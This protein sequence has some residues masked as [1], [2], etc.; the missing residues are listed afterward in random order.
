ML[1]NNIQ[2]VDRYNRPNA[3]TILGLRTLFYN[4]GV[5]VDPVEIAGVAIFPASSNMLPEAI[6]NSSG[7]ISDSVFPTFNTVVLSGNTPILIT[8]PLSNGINGF[9]QESLTSQTINQNPTTPFI[10]RLGVGDYVN[11]IH[12][13]SIG[14]YA[15]GIPSLGI[16]SYY[17]FIDSTGVNAVNNIGVFAENSSSEIKQP[18][19]AS[20]V[21]NRP[22]K[23]LD[24][25]T[26]KFN[27]NS[28]FQTFINEF[29]VFSNT[30]TAITE[31]LLV[32]VNSKLIN[33]HVQLGEKISLR[34]TNEL[35]VENNNISQAFINTLKG[36]A[37]AS[38]SIEIRKISDSPAIDAPTTVSSFANTAATTYTTS[39]DTIV[40]NWDTTNLPSILAGKPVKGTYS[41][42]AKFSVSDQVKITPL[43][44]LIVS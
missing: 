27:Q 10:I 33:K 28:K 35:R 12:P 4:D 42:Q 43:M 36:S 17:N 41:V 44:Y 31:P 40:F 18:T 1:I 32:T 37:I 25:W 23:Y 11:V 26:V 34:I 29:Q 16:N 6:L 22:G 39:D 13:N 19:P 38:P 7:L 8:N 15:S 30:F 24:A 14:V 5:L 3:N 21:L 2:V 9:S 20:G